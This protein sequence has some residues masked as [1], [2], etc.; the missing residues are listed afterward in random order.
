M[1]TIDE[2]KAQMA[3]DDFADHFRAIRNTINQDTGHLLVN[4]NDAI[5]PHL[6]VKWWF[7][8]TRAVYPK[9]LVDAHGTKF[10]GAIWHGTLY[11]VVHDDNGFFY[12]FTNLLRRDKPS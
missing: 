5:V 4:D 9:E 7:N 1:S 11:T 8:R 10:R 3:V 12:V 6:K 2:Y